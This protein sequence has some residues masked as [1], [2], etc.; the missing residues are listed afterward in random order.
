MTKVQQETSL[1]RKKCKMKQHGKSARGIQLLRSR[2]MT[3]IWIRS[4]ALACTC[5]ILVTPPLIHLQTLKT[6]H[7]VPIILVKPFFF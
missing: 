6:L 1:T 2:K 7:Q 4:S 3:K 5:S